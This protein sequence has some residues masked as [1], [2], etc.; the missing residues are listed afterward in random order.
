M[1]ADS[2]FNRLSQMSTS[3]TILFQAI[4]AESSSQSV[5]SARRQILE[6][7]ELVSRR[8]LRGLL[9]GWPNREEAAEDCY[10]E[11]A[12]RF[13]SGRFRGADP[14]RGRFRDYL[15]MVLRNLAT[16]YQRGLKSKI[17]PLEEIEPAITAEP[18]SDSNQLF[19]D[20]WREELV[21][22]TLAALAEHDRSTGQHLYAVLKLR[23]DRPSA[24]SAEMA[25][26]LSKSLGQ[27]VNDNWVRKRLFQARE[28][29]AELLIDEVAYSLDVSDD[30]RIAA[31][32]AD[33]GLLD[34]CRDSLT[35]R[36]Q[37]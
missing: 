36:G 9:R 24:R 34:Y 31:E 37:T 3:W 16:D 26:E 10:Q 20:I 14:A 29:F 1:P 35:R 33:V 11:F 28:R 12:L 8:Y 23:M 4:E 15:K 2:P 27:A 21:S 5:E 32:L 17:A 18:D 22:R 30:D 19:T 7:Y 6:R 13:V 25:E